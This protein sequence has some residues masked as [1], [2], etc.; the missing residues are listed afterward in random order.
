ML[1]VTAMEDSQFTYLS[2]EAF[3][4]IE[5]LKMEKKICLALHFNLNIV[6][7]HHY[8][9]RF[10]RASYVS[11]HRYSHHN[12]SITK[13]ATIPPPC[14]FKWNDNEMRFMMD[15]LLE[16]AMVEFKFVPI[17]PS[18][19]AAGAVYL[20][21]ATFNIRDFSNHDTDNYEDRFGYFFSPALEHYTGYNVRELVHV[22]MLLH[23]AL[24]VSKNAVYDK[25]S[26]QQYQRVALNVP[27]DRNQLFPSSFDDIIPKESEC[28]IDKE[29]R[30]QSCKGYIIF[31][32]WASCSSDDSSSSIE[33]EYFNEYLI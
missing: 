25:Y 1:D 27:V 17:R 9:P 5:L 11:S 7:A 24:R 22:V 32:D 23:T 13:H 15:Y 6:T 26:K 16:I 31:E 29:E 2:G 12:D 21:R 4:E 3:G 8:V 10:L 14:S 30:S 18:L 19:V 28:D 33:D 20:A